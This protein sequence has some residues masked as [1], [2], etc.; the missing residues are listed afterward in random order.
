MSLIVPHHQV[1][2]N[3]VP[4]PRAMVEDILAR[5][6]LLDAELGSH[7]GPVPPPSPTSSM[8]SPR[9][10][11]SGSQV[12]ILQATAW[13]GCLLAVHTGTVICCCADLRG[14]PVP[15]KCEST[16]ACMQVPASMLAGGP[17]EA[18][19][20]LGSQAHGASEGLPGHFEQLP[21]PQQS[22]QQAWP[23]VTAPAPPAGALEAPPGSGM[24]SQ[25]HV[26]PMP[27]GSMPQ[28][29]FASPNCLPHG[30]FRTSSSVKK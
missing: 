20:R 5:V 21:E 24:E 30:A 12:S 25:P 3:Q 18:E 15:C 7:V 28:V 6:T 17:G 27:V 26:S 2:N 14:F 16:S 1:R 13:L 23:A 8:G 9:A 10:S 19:G 4:K 22:A 29:G 11:S